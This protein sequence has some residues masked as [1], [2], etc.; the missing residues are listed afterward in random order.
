MCLRE[1]VSSLSPH[2]LH[3]PH[4][5]AGWACNE[6]DDCEA[7]VFRTDDHRCWFK[8]HTGPLSFATSEHIVVTA[9]GKYLPHEHYPKTAP[10]PASSDALRKTLTDRRTRHLRRAAEL[11]AKH[12]ELRRQHVALGQAVKVS[13]FFLLSMYD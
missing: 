8:S 3:I 11:N 1:P 10:I 5:A 12:I 4:P 13:G 7:A 6:R 9:V 2:T